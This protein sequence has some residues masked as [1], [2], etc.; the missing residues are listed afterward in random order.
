MPTTM[1]DR[2]QTESNWIKVKWCWRNFS[3][4]SLDP[5][6]MLI[7]ILKPEKILTFKEIENVQE[8]WMSM[9]MEHTYSDTMLDI[10]VR[11]KRSIFAPF[12][13]WIIYRISKKNDSDMNNFDCVFNVQ[14][15]LTS[16]TLPYVYSGWKKLK[17]NWTGCA[18][19]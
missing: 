1:A 10:C 16:N 17:E 11:Q 12:V 7:S 3:C 19:T 5:I 9:Q 18:V 15:P 8:N 6:W 4:K 13:S 14:E 2:Y